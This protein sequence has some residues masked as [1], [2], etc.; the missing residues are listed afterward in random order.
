MTARVLLGA[1]EAA[2]IAPLVDAYLT[3]FP[4]ADCTL[5]EGPTDDRTRGAAGR[6]VPTPMAVVAAMNGGLIADVAGGVGR[7]RGRSCDQLFE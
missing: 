5:G 2:E 6:S 3:R 1:H 4:R 7:A